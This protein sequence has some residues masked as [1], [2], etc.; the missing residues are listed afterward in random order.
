MVT[1]LFVVGITL[2][3]TYSDIVCLLYMRLHIMTN[4]S[5]FLEVPL[6]TARP[7][8]S[9]LPSYQIYPFTSAE[10]SVYTVLAP[11][12]SCMIFRSLKFP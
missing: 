4:A 9:Q 1:F 2:S 8:R 12:A 10:Y 3:S 11:R 6:F 5:V 7:Q